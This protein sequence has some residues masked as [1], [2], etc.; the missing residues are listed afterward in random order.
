MLVKPLRTSLA[1]GG[2]FA[3][4]NGIAGLK[5]HSSR[6]TFAIATD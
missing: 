2:W 3:D 1:L 5:T 6:T 4:V